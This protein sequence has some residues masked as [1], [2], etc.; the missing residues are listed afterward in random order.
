[1][2]RLLLVD[3]HPIVREGLAAVL[4]DEPDFTV[5]GSIGSAEEALASLAELRPDIILLDLE[6]PGLGGVEAIPRLLAAAP[7]ARIVVFTAYDTEE[8]VLGAIRAGAK[9]YLLKGAAADEITRAI[10]AVHQGESHLTPRVAARVV[11]EVSAPGRGT[12]LTDRERQVL[13]LIAGGQPTKQIASSLSITERT[14]K[15][16]VASIFNKLGVSSR[17]EAVAQAA[18]RG[19]L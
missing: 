11:A 14:V 8:R 9:G 4:E 13:R 17:A 2:I 5:V 16:H 6:M 15:F 12:A 18:Q 19:L 10:R 3:D 1:V 7:W